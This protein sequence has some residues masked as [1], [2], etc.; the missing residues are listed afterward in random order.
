M[1]IVTAE[2]RVLVCGSRRWADKAKLWRVLDFVNRERRI[3]TI[4]HGGARGADTLAGEWAKWQEIE[5]VVYLALWKKNGGAAGPI[6]NAQMIA[7][8]GPDVCVAFR[9]FG[10]SRGTDDMIRKAINASIDV[11]VIAE[12]LISDE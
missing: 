12:E 6:R 2:Y 11:H 4:I 9:R 1:P 3:T 5:Q 7:E 10:R 8:G